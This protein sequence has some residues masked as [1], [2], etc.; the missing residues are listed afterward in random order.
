[1]Q[2]I[3][4][5][6]AA[7]II[8][9]Q[10]R[11][12]GRRD[13]PAAT[14]S[15]VAPSPEA[16]LQDTR[17]IALRDRVK[18]QY[19]RRAIPVSGHRERAQ[20]QR[21][22]EGAIPEVLPRDRHN[23]TITQRSCGDAFCTKT[24]C[25][26]CVSGET[27]TPMSPPLGAPLE[28]RIARAQRGKGHL[29]VESSPL[30]RA[31]ESDRQGAPEK[32]PGKSGD[33]IWS[34]SC[35]MDGR[36]SGGSR[37]RRRERSANTNARRGASSRPFGMLLAFAIALLAAGGPSIGV[38]AATSPISEALEARILG[39]RDATSRERP[40]S[41]MGGDDVGREASGHGVGLGA[42]RALGRTSKKGGS[43]SYSPKAKGGKT[44]DP[45]GL[46]A[47]VIGGNFTLNGKSS[48]VAQYD[49]VR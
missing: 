29:S 6:I 46:S 35:W 26:I 3:L 8:A 2:G 45:E 15:T 37:K 38:G 31:V 28:G 19:L 16:L 41:S 34:P 12:E 13:G 42:R 39:E 27:L 7:E 44:S 4:E 40:A 49:P 21:I 14:P 25:D 43:S 10:W 1:M 36:S 32:E 17:S 18:Q 11:H 9:T 22:R 30:W 24:R 23:S 20:K 47:L 48:N 33:Q 5:S